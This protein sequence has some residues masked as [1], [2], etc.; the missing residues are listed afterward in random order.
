MDNI[1]IHK[2]SFLFLQ[3]HPSGFNRSVSTALKHSVTNKGCDWD[4]MKNT[5]FSQNNINY[6]NN[7]IKRSVYNSSCEKFIVRNQKFEHIY[8]LMEGIWDQHAQHLPNEKQKQIKILNDYT[9]NFGTETILEEIKFRSNYLRD[10]FS[11]PVTLP[12]PINDSVSGTNTYAP[13]IG[14]DKNTF[15][16]YAPSSSEPVKNVYNQSIMPDNDMVIMEDFNARNK[17]YF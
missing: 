15:D 1:D 13:T 14:F 10:K 11:K 6:I 9:I 5:F 17:H 8:K 4:A 2:A 12:D 16:I 3:D 7:E